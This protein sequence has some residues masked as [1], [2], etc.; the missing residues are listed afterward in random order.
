VKRLTGKRHVGHAGTLDPFAS[1]VL[2]IL[3]G[4]ATKVMEY[5]LD[6]SKT[7]LAEIELGKNTDTGDI[8]GKVIEELPVTNI[9]LDKIKEALSHFSGQ[10]LQVPHRY[11]ALKY[12]GRPMYYWARMGVNPELK[13]RQIIIY[14]LELVKCNFPFF[15]M[16]VDCSKGTYI[17]SIAR[18]IGEILGCGAYLKS[19]IRERY[20]AFSLEE[21]LSPDQL[22]EVI[23]EGRQETY[24]Y[25]LDYALTNVPAIILDY[26]ATVEVCKGKNIRAAHVKPEGQAGYCRAYSSDGAFVAVMRWVSETGEWHPEKVFYGQEISSI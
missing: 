20:G 1:G 6:V 4:R 12:R 18:D 14:S 13:P 9:T 23:R 17:R 11:S 19:L 26:S 21:A 24:M 7:Y 25:P 5:L 16:R 10:I 8:Q 22:E 15:T 2:P 3:V